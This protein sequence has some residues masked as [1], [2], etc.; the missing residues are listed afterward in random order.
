MVHTEVASWRATVFAPSARR[1]TLDCCLENPKGGVPMHDTTRI[2]E[3]LGP[4]RFGVLIAGGPMHGLFWGVI[5]HWGG[6]RTRV[7][8]ARGWRRFLLTVTV[9]TDPLRPPGQMQESAPE[10]DTISCRRGRPVLLLS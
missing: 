4:W 9:P 5:Y 7:G 6:P 3:I 1:L 2:T 10:R 8:S